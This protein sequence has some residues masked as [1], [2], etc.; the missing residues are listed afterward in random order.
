MVCTKKCLEQSGS[1]LY[2]YSGSYKSKITYQPSVTSLDTMLIPKSMYDAVINRQKNKIIAYVQTNPQYSFWTYNFNQMLKFSYNQSGQNK[3]GCCYKMLWKTKGGS[4]YQRVPFNP[5][6]NLYTYLIRYNRHSHL[7]YYNH[8]VLKIFQNMN[9]ARQ[10]L[11]NNKSYPYQNLVK[12]TNKN[13]GKVLKN[14][15]NCF[16]KLGYTNY[17]KLN[18]NEYLYWFRE[19]NIFTPYKPIKMDLIKFNKNVNK[20]V[21]FK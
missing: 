2:S 18:S 4:K 15:C 9:L 8:I 1:P 3:T 7:A 6:V 21:E 14:K 16:N 11:G 5:M 17:R 10:M 20:F 19:N 12:N 13:R